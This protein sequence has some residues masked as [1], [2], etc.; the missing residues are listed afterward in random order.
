M[1]TYALYDR[2]V[3]VLLFLCACGLSATIFGAVSILNLL[4]SSKSHRRGWQWS[5][6]GGNHGATATVV[7]PEMAC[8]LP[9]DRNGANRRANAWI[10]MLMFDVLIF[11]MTVYKSWRRGAR[12]RRSLFKV[13]LRDGTIYFGIIVIVELVTVLT[14]HVLPE[15][16]RGFT[17]TFATIVKHDDEQ[18]D[19]QPS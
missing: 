15:Y 19:A 6:V 8:Y 7:S 17:A 16:Q 12:I 11:S 13:L 4:S 5:V 9:L 10:G 18:T 1:R 2:N 14:F 3:I